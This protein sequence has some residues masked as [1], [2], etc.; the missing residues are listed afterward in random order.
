MIFLPVQ[1]YTFYRNID[2]PLEP[3]SWNTLHG[4]AWWEIV[5]IPTYGSVEFDRWIEIAL[6]FTVFACFGLGRDAVAMYRKWLLQAGLGNMFPKLYHERLPS[7]SAAINSCSKVSSYRSKAR[8]FIVRNLSHKRS[9]RT[10]YVVLKDSYHRLA[11]IYSSTSENPSIITALSTPSSADPEKSFP[12]LKR[13]SENRLAD[14][15][16]TPKRTEKAFTDELNPPLPIFRIRSWVTMSMPQL[17][18]RPESR[19]AVQTQTSGEPTPGFIA[20][21]WVSSGSPGMEDR[22]APH[23]HTNSIDLKIEQMN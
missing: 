5:L 17:L 3:Y 6:G 14:R 23:G 9:M 15:S 7:Y 22:H 11:L 1:G 18:L 16:D 12:C 21:D 13:N 4:P 20:H 2:Y 8:D 19:V 10:S